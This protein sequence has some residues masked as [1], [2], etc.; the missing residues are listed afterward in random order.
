MF[1][2]KARNDSTKQIKL[3]FRVNDEEEYNDDE[4][5]EEDHR[6]TFQ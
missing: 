6:A 1:G 2:W 5:E 3:P 4:E